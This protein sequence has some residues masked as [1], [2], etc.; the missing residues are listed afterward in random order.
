[1]FIHNCHL[2]GDDYNCFFEDKLC[3]IEPQTVG[4][5]PILPPLGWAH[6]GPAESIPP[7]KPLAAATLGGAMSSGGN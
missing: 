6:R 7:G 4:L 2:F 3:A 5:V 1:M